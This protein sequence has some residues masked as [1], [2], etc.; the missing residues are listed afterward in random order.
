LRN[1]QY[2]ISVRVY[3][4][5]TRSEVVRFADGAWRVR[6]SVPPVNGKANRELIALLSRVLGVSQSRLSVVRGHASRNKTVA[7]DSL[8]QEEVT[9]R[10]SRDPS[11]KPF[12]SDVASR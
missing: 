6:V 11:A 1:S 8:S 3:P 10:L 5:A 9:E 12:S 2:K 7:V 4:G